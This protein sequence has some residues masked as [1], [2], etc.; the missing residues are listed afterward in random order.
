M[1][2]KPSRLEDEYFAREDAEKLYRLH[3][4]RLKS[5][6]KQKQEDEKK[7]HWMKCPKCGYGLEHIK[8]REHTID[9][10]FRCGAIVLDHNEFEAIDSKEHTDGFLSGFVSLFKGI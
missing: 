8:W 7:Q 10:C 9:K 4:E 6:D 1:T 5:E 2:E 3:Q